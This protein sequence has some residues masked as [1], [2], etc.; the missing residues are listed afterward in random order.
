MSHLATGT[1]FG[2][3]I[4]VDMHIRHCKH[5][6]PAF[7]RCLEQV[8]AQQIG[9]ILAVAPEAMLP[10]LTVL[11]VSRSFSIPPGKPP[12][13]CEASLRLMAT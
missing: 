13:I 9:G 10:P 6:T 12:T 5:G 4:H 7:R 2:F 8:I 11:P 1:S 3:A